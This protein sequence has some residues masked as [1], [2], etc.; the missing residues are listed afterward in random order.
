[1]KGKLTKPKKKKENQKYE[2][3]NLKTNIRQCVDGDCGFDRG[4]FLR[5]RSSG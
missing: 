5:F 1:M 2:D 3:K 4:A